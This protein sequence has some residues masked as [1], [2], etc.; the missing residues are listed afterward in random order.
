MTSERWNSSLLGNGGKQV[1][2]ETYTHI[3]I[4][5]LLN[6]RD[7]FTLPFLLMEQKT[8]SKLVSVN[9]NEDARAACVSD[10]VYDYTASISSRIFFVLMLQVFG[11]LPC[12]KVNLSL[13]LTN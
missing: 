6:Y 5:K 1:P 7:N 9:Y 2:E 10:T 13:C 8:Y 3:T 11:I 4:E 12:K